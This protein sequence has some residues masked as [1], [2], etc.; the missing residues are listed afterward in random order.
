MGTDHAYGM[1]LRG[2]Y[3]EAIEV[4]LGEEAESAE[5]VPILAMAA[6]AAEA[7]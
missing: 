5:R 2:D 6:A 4:A 1:F 3:E 7:Y